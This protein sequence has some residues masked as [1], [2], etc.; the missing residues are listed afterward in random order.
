MVWSCSCFAPF[1]NSRA[2]SSRPGRREQVLVIAGAGCEKARPVAC[3]RE[4][5]HGQHGAVPPQDANGH[6]QAKAEA[7]DK[8]IVIPEEISSG[9][10]PVA[11]DMAEGTDLEDQAVAATAELEFYRRRCE[12]LE[13]MC[14]MLKSQSLQPSEV[15]MV[16]DAKAMPQRALQKKQQDTDSSDEVTAGEQTELQQTSCV[17]AAQ[18]AGILPQEACDASTAVSTKMLSPQEACDFS[19]DRAVL[20]PQDACD[21]STAVSTKASFNSLEAVVEFECDSPLSPVRQVSCESYESTEQILSLDSCGSLV[22]VGSGGISPEKERGWRMQ[23]LLGDQAKGATSQPT[24][25]TLKYRKSDKDCEDG[26]RWEEMLGMASA[27]G[28]AATLQPEVADAPVAGATL[29]KRAHSTPPPTKPPEEQKKT[30]RRRRGSTGRRKL[31]KPPLLPQRTTQAPEEDIESGWRWEEMFGQGEPDS[32]KRKPKQVKQ[33][34][35]SHD[36]EKSWRWQECSFSPRVVSASP[37]PLLTLASASPR[38]QYPSQSNTALPAS[39]FFPGDVAPV[40][41][42]ADADVTSPVRPA[43]VAD[44][45][46][47]LGDIVVLGANTPAEYRDCPAVVV[48]VFASHCSVIVLDE[49]RR[50]GVGECWPNFEDVLVDSCTLRLGTRIVIDGMCGKRTQRFNGHSGTISPHPREGHPVLI[51]KPSCPDSPQ[52]TVCVLFDNPQ[53]TGEKSALLEPRFLFR[54][55]EAVK[56]VTKCLGDAVASLVAMSEA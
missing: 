42:I 32:P 41:D 36:C 53:E 38:P 3:A 14:A 34:G 24:S 17:D 37:R 39:P 56:R 35:K 21:A 15:Q 4:L 44:G 10:D 29:D 12:E 40:P 33:H 8:T 48:E 50:F 51:R 5:Q 26:W 7:V 1:A 9:R 55:D 6:A 18:S 19:E 27:S 2:G 54:Y 46:P 47:Q 25:R 49:D 43:S 22:I 30:R 13:R 20:L 23:E 28:T 52:L 11:S 45:I 31:A 16:P